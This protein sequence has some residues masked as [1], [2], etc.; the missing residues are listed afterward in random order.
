MDLLLTAQFTTY[1][2]YNQKNQKVGV[3]TKDNNN[4][5]YTLELLIKEKSELPLRL[6]VDEPIPSETLLKFLQSRVLPLNRS[7]LQD[8]MKVRGFL[9]FT[10]EDLIELNQGRVYTDDFYVLKDNQEFRFGN[11]EQKPCIELDQDI[12]KLWSCLDESK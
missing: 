10:W 9:S 7:G 12:D 2:I 8:E 5:T 11:L 6:Q 3:I 4:D 1:T